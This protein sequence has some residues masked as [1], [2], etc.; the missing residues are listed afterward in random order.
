MHTTLKNIIRQTPPPAHVGRPLSG[1]NYIT[2]LN[3][4]NAY[5]AA[6]W[7]CQ[8]AQRNINMISLLVSG[9]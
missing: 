8:K 2:K 4:I 3:K 1:V 7:E 9:G 5:T 6:V